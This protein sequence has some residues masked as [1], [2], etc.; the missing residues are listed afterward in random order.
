[1]GLPD[2]GPSFTFP[3]LAPCQLCSSLPPPPT[4][5]WDQENAAGGARWIQRL[6][7]SRFQTQKTGLYRNSEGGEVTFPM[8]EENPLVLRGPSLR[9]EKG[10]SS[11]LSSF[12]FP[13]MLLEA[14]PSPV[15]FCHNDVQEG[16][17][18]RG[19]GPSPATGPQPRRRS[20][21]G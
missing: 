14:T 11:F 20:W 5:P 4:S 1:M 12:L 16:E 2:S 8:A 18:G 13:R 6:G 3:S 19:S 9:K 17:G 21:L 10:L 15:V 7:P